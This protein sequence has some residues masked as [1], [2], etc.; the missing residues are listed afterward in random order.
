[1][2]GQDAGLEG[3]LTKKDEPVPIRVAAR[4]I[5][6]PDEAKAFVEIFEKQKDSAL[7]QEGTESY[8]LFKTLVTIRA[9]CWCMHL[10]CFISWVI[11]KC[12]MT[13]LPSPSSLQLLAPI[14][15]A[16]PSPTGVRN[17]LR[18]YEVRLF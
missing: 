10:P 8:R 6:S 17:R 1:M 18:K 2:S 16:L 13:L 11:C 15:V 5:V 12:T 9:S 3:M 4:Y 7:K 14:G